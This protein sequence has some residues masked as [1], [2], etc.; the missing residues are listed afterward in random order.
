[1][2]GGDFNLRELALDGYVYVGGRDVDHVFVRGLQ[3]AGPLEVLDG[4][5]L[6]DHP[7]L[8]VSLALPGG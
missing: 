6:S 4:G 1:V 8:A 2:L 5:R 7:P 3:L